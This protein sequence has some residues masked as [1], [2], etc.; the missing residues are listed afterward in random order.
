MGQ[1]NTT[2]HEAPASYATPTL[3]PP[4]FAL[5]T[6]FRTPW[7]PLVRVVHPIHARPLPPS[8]TQDTHEAMAWT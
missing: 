2:T 5:A 3:H 8:I 7:A 1:P 6:R 4:S